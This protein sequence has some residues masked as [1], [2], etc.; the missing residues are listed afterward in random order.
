MKKNTSLLNCT[1]ALGFLVL[2]GNLI[3]LLLP[4]EQFG[5]ILK[6]IDFALLLYVLAVIGFL[7]SKFFCRKREKG[8][9]KE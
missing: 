9:E 7:M 5:A 8:S 6:T 3:R 4:A 2:W 1:I